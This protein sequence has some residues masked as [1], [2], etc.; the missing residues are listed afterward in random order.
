MEKLYIIMPAYNEE[1][2][3]ERVVRGWH[4]VV[5]K[6]GTASRLVVVDDGSIDRT[7][8][9]LRLLTEELSQL[10]LLTKKNGGHG[11]AVLYGYRYAIKKKADY[12]FQT[13]ADGQTM[14]REFPEFWKKRHQM[15]AVI[16]YRRHRKDGVSRIIVTK[17]LKLILKL[18]FS[19]SVVD[20]N[21]PFRL[22]KREM[23][24]KYMPLVPPGFHLSN[25]LLTVLFIK[26]KEKVEF[27]PITFR[28][29]QG[30]VNSINIRKII[31][32]GMRAVLDFWRLKK[33]MISES[34]G[35][36]RIR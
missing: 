15:D 2:T 1:D 27:I 9:K 31:K 25:V 18:I 35:R 26:N 6:I 28:P 30:G 32:I 11:A 16:G 7:Y 4:R 19:V 34:G 3:I 12:I 8:A 23:L 36:Y 5:K 33:L 14:P 22:M 13:D 17:I 29:R 21:A 20:A 24:E 10:E